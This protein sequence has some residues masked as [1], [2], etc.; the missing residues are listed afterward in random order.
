MLTSIVCGAPPVSRSAFDVFRA[1]IARV[2]RRCIIERAP[3][4]LGLAMVLFTSAASA[5]IPTAERNYLISLYNQ[6]NGATWTFNTNWL[7]SVG[8]E[9]TWFGVIC[10]AEKDRVEYVLLASNNLSGTLPAGLSALTT[11][12]SFNVGSN[13]ITGNV[14][15]VGSV[16]TLKYLTLSNNQF[17]GTVPSLNQVPELLELRL[18]SNALVGPLPSFASNAKLITLNAHMNAFTGATPN[19]ENNPHVE[20]VRLFGNQLTGH[21]P[22]LGHLKKLKVFEANINQLSGPLPQLTGLPELSVFNVNTNQISGVIPPLTQLPKLTEFRAAWNQLTGAIPPLNEVAA[23]TILQLSVNKL[24]GSLP[25]FASN[26]ALKNIYVDENQLTGTVPTAPSSLLSSGSSLC[27]NQLTPATSPAWDIATGVSPW[28]QTCI[29]PKLAQSIAFVPPTPVLAI[30]EPVTAI[31][32]GTPASGPTSVI[33]YSSATPAI[34][35]INI[36]TGAVNTMP[37]ARIGS[38]CTVAAD[39]ASDSFY[40]TAAQAT[41]SMV[42]T[43]TVDKASCKLD[44]DGDALIYAHTD[45]LL[46]LRYLFGMR[47]AALTSGLSLTGVRSSPNDI[48]S[49]LDAFDFDVLG[50]SPPALAS[51][52]RDGGVVYRFM[53]AQQGAKLVAGSGI[54]PAQA[55]TVESNV[56]GWCG[57]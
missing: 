22:S 38:V 26:P 41:L 39:R 33:L 30:S 47:N 53:R 32:Q 40:N 12:I 8:S 23:L 51:A 35:S 57:L 37:G 4:A 16:P 56:A 7:G 14:P 15:S 52:T 28:H 54:D 46:L 10:N 43:R 20:G 19:F 45:G 31:A 13:Q 24:T 1:E 9:C 21:I 5:Q 25:S 50:N 42:V 2:V 29:P 44:V 49:F 11:L 3:T 55:A 6:T 34:C 36:A 18:N 27:S 17:T 48:V